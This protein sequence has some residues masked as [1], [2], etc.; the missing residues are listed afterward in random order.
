MDDSVKLALESALV[1]AEDRA[2]ELA[3]DVAREHVADELAPNT[4]RAYARPWQAWSEHCARR[5]VP[6]TPVGADELI[7]YLTGLSLGGSAPATVRLALAAISVVDQRARVT[8]SERQPAP[9]RSD[10]LVRAW[11]K[12][13]SRQ[14]RHAPQKRAPVLS[15]QQVESVIRAAQER[16]RNVAPLAHAA[17][18][19]RDRA[20]LLIGVT[21]ALRVS[22]LVALELGD[23]ETDADGRGLLVTVRRSKTDQGGRG[24]TVG[25]L[26]QG[27]SIRC[28]VEAWMQ[29]RR[30]RGDWPGA[31]FVAI[32]RS[33]ELGRKA[34]DES[35]GRRIVV[36]RAKAAGIDLTSHTMR[37]TLATRAAQQGK[38]VHKI[39]AQGGWRSVQTLLRYMDDGQIFDDNASAGLLDD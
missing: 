23:V 34:L 13:W 1:L 14:H 18:Y 17:H 12:G 30:L 3:R 16:P 32:E 31:A 15:P 39:A 35:T 29:W 7:V 36:R 9:V 8:E 6:A 28:P 11:H 25:V 38:S 27:R 19:A 5:G 20:M 24:R 21:A 26:P 37:R 10:P 33:G 4:R 22:E 2:I